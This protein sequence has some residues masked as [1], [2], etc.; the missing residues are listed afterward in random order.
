MKIRIKLL[1]AALAALTV[2]GVAPRA[3]A[4]PEPAA[5]DTTAPAADP[6]P[7]AAREA[8]EVTDLDQ[9]PEDPSA[10]FN[11]FNFSYR[12]K[13]QWGGK[14]GDGVMT[15]KGPSGHESVVHEEEPMSP[16]FVFMLVNFGIFLWLLAK[17]LLP[18]GQQLAK[19]R[20]DQIKNALD[21]A[22]DLRDKASAK[23][24]EE[25]SA[26][27]AAATEKLLRERTTPEDQRKLVSTFIAGMGGN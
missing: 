24:A 15:E 2:A 25:V 23:L 17:Y 5:A 10:H 3:F 16:P 18:A 19:E 7:E 4:Q 1:L 8:A 6:S 12:G 9:E 21:E 13:D 22:A 27:A 26:A 20:H 11:F 14:F